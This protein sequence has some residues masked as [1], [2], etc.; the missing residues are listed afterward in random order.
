MNGC[1]GTMRK[2]VTEEVAKVLGKGLPAVAGAKH[3]LSCG[4][5]SWQERLGW[6]LGQTSH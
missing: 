4:Q 2:G 5:E 3:N 6:E 1:M